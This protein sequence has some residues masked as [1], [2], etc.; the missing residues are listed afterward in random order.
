MKITSFR[1]SRRTV[2]LLRAILV[3]E[4]IGLLFGGFKFYNQP[5]QAATPPSGSISPTVGTVVNWT[6][7]K[8]GVPAAANGEPSCTTGD[9]TATNCDVFTLTVPAGPWV[10]KRIHVR[11]TWTS[12]T[13]DYD[14]VVRH[15]SNG[16]AGMQ[17]D[18]VAPVP[19]PTP[20]IP[21]LD[22]VIATSANGT[23]TLEEVI[24]APPDNGETYYIR[25]IY[26]AP[27]PLDQYNGSATVE[28]VVTTAPPV[29]ACAMP[30]Y[31]NYQPPQFL[32]GTMTP[33]PRRDSSPEPSIGV[34]WNTGN[35]MTMSRLQCNRT[36]FDDLMSPA[37]PTTAKWFPQKLPAAVT[38]LDPIL[39]TDSVTGRTICGELQGAL[40]ATNGIIT[41]DDLTTPTATFQT[42]A[43]SGEDHQ[44][45]GGGPPK[46]GIA[47]RE[48][49][50][51]YPNLF[52]Y[53]SQ[54]IATATVATSLNGG[55]SYLP[56]VP[57]Y[58]LAQCGGLHGH[59]KVAPDGTVYLPNKGCQGKVG[60]ATSQD[61]GLT[62]I[63]NTIPTSTSGASDPSI[64]IGAG[65][66][67]FV[68]YIGGDNHPHV[69][70]SDD[71]AVTWHDDFDFSTALNPF[72]AAVFPEAVAG[73]NNRASVF[74]LATTS[75]N[76]GDPVGTDNGGAGPNFA[77]TWYPYIATT[78]DGG[79]SWSVVR[80][81]NDPLNPGVKNP[82]Q[83]GVICTNGTT[84]PSGPP[85]TRN[86]ADFN[87]ISVDA[88]GRIVA[89]YAD[90]CNFGHRCINIPDNQP[91][92]NMDPM[93]GATRLNNQGT[94]RLTIIRQRGGVRL[95]QEFD[96]ASAAQPAAPFVNI[97]QSKKGTMLL[98]GTPDDNDSAILSYRI[99]R[100]AA[101][102]GEKLLA[103]VKANVNTFVDRKAKRGRNYYYHVTAVNALGESP[104]A[105]KTF[106]SKNS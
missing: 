42:G 7:D 38:G 94:A 17:G 78:C 63:V 79:K 62:W 39:F 55:V 22:D 6:G 18:G 56:A 60:L 44:T 41:D 31:D 76:G 48:P 93:T 86:L 85:D 2:V 25:A 68:G 106:V 12:P 66:R 51:S 89:V 91:V 50:G 45:I 73:D 61:N 30:T 95:F 33:Y 98:W 64:G 10:G 83:Q 82:A 77:G 28:S 90:G 81:D 57:A 46:P 23:N 72:T 71:K 19:A 101:G 80:A 105:V 54:A 9:S 5:V 1:C 27:D 59:I 11:F 75:T 35:V 53:A 4:I 100:G 47:N 67:L 103:E 88:R 37:D 24:L 40:G 20:P 3:L 43:T 32:P 13:T 58:T 102:E 74:F 26:F 21:P 8:T 49:T 96:A 16:T 87:E 36:S 92:T 29:S 52:Y 97:E 69:A 14:M 84:C 70:V 99:Y 15:E 104:K 34:N 65:G